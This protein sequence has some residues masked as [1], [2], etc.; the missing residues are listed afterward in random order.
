MQADVPFP[1][2]RSCED[3]FLQL[4]VLLTSLL[5]VAYLAFTKPFI[6]HRNT[7][8]K[9]LGAVLEPEQEDGS[10]HPVAYA[11]RS[12]LNKSSGTDTDH[13]LR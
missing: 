8:G 5:V 10:Q 13:A 6:L 11:S 1:W 9:G 7:S 2:S 3:A 12:L 4:K